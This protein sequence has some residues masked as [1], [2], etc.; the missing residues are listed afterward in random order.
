MNTNID[1]LNIKKFFLY[2]NEKR[3]IKKNENKY[4]TKIIEYNFYSLNEAKICNVI[5]KI[6]YYMNYF[7]IIEDYDFVNINQLNDRYIE[8]INFEN[9]K[10]LIFKYKNNRVIKFNDLIFSLCEPKLFIKN[11]IESF[12]CILKSIS[13]LDKRNI[14][15]FDLS[16]ENIIFNFD[17]GEKIQMQGFGNSL[18]ITELNEEY[19]TKIIQKIENYTHKPI[20]VHVLFY[21]I[22]NDIKSISYSFIEEICEIFVD[23]L[24]VLNLFTEKYKIKYKDLCIESLKKYINKSRSYIIEDILIYSD[25]WDV[26]SFS[27]IFLHIFGNV[28]SVFSLKQTF[29]SKITIELSKNINPDPSKRMSM[30]SLSKIFDK[31][32]YE[33]KD[34]DFV[35]SL[36]PGKMK[37]L[38]SILE[39]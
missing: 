25:K 19:I 26:Y 6:P 37:E 34:W 32:L 11:I 12:Q 8:K 10:N 28:S 18:L 3:T 15:I 21:L 36:N 35:Q 9:K 22:Q 4:I 14:C 24:N 20:E 39:N 27:V 1:L 38:F 17:C 33:E 30:E 31:L 16:P 7:L 23:K 2:A 29:I 13:I 5:K